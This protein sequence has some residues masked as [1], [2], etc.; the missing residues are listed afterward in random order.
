MLITS[1]GSLP[2]RIIRLSATAEKLFAR[3]VKACEG[4]ITD[5]RSMAGT[6]PTDSQFTKTLDAGPVH[7]IV[8]LCDALLRVVPVEYSTPA[9]F[10]RRTIKLDQRGVIRSN[11]LRH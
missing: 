3:R 7:C 10:S 4:G 1:K 11:N 6:A 9:V 5:R 8:W 2:Q